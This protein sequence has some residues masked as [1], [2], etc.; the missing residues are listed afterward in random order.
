MSECK[1]STSTV[2]KMCRCVY[3]ERLTGVPNVVA[4]GPGQWAFKGVNKIEESPGQNNNVVNVEIH[5]NHLGCEPHPC[6][7][8]DV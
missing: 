8:N 7:T 1:E 2:L 5:H 4:C 3:R 6:R